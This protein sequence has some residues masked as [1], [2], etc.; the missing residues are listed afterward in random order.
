MNAPV[1]YPVKYVA[2]LTGVREVS[3]LGT[4][5]LGFW[6]DALAPESLVA[7]ERDGR[8]QVM[9]IAADARFRGIGFRE[10]SFSVLVAPPGDVPGDVAGDVPGRDAAYLVAAFNSR[11]LFALSERVFFSTPY[12]HADIDVSPAP[13]VSIRIRRRGE[14]LFEARRSDAVVP[15]GNVVDGSGEP[16]NGWEGPVFVPSDRRSATGRGRYFIARIGGD[17]RRRAFAGEDSVAI[18]PSGDDGVFKAL[19]DSEFVAR[20]WSVRADATHAKSKTYKRAAAPR[21][22]PA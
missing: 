7:A 18:A 13:P 17:A 6:K 5:D 19:R 12:R 1:K 15:A 10:V 2:E 8:A 9:I 21:A 22:V 3:L 14:V 16:A 4:A 11:R 20:E